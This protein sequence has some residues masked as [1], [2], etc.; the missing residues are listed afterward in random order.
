MTGP[1]D[2]LPKTTRLLWLA[3]AVGAA[4]GALAASRAR[5]PEKSQLVRAIDVLAIG[6]FLVFLGTQRRV[7]LRGSRVL[8][9]GVGAATVTYNAINLL[10]QQ[11]VKLGPLGLLLALPGPP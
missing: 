8:L 10:R 3:V 4:V 1:L 2:A 5:E 11:G 7:L 6:P 9:A